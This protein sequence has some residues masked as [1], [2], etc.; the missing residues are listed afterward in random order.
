MRQNF[1]AYINEHFKN[2]NMK[3]VHNLCQIICRIH[4]LDPSFLWIRPK[5]KDLLCTTKETCEG[6]ILI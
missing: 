4:D 1:A 2:K 6:F 5:H 3:F